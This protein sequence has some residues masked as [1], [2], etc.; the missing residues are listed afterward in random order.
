MTN[1][2][3]LAEDEEY[4]FSVPEDKH[5]WQKGPKQNYAASVQINATCTQVA[6]TKGLRDSSLKGGVHPKDDCKGHNID[7]HIAKANSCQ[8]GHII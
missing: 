2:W 1:C 5:R 7:C 4:L 8:R 6:G 3:V